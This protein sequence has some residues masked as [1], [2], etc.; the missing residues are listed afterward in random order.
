[1]IDTTLRAIAEPNRRTI[2]QIT[3]LRE[4]SAGEIAAYFNLTR[5][6]IS[7]HLRVLSDAGL[8]SM[9]RE[10]AKRMYRARPEGIQEVKEFLERFWGD[11]LTSLKQAAEAEERLSQ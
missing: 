4:L 6:A 2:L 8:V 11:R 10:G 7:Q 3:H 9:R 5:P 1:M